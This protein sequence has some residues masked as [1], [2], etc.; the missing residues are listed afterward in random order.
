MASR[1]TTIRFDKGTL[2]LEE[3]P[4]F[5]TQSALE[6]KWDERTRTW[7]APAHRYR[8]IVLLLR[9]QG[10]P[11]ADRARAFSPTDFPLRSGLRPRD[12]QEAAMRAWLSG[13]RR[14][15]IVLPTG[16]GKTIVALLLIEKTRR[17]ALIHVPTIDLMHQW[18]AVLSEHFGG[19][20]GLLGGGYKELASLTVATYDSALLHVTSKG[21]RFGFLIFDECHHLPGPQYQFAALGSIAP[22]R[23]GLTA[24]PERADGRDRL[25]DDLVGPVCY[26]ARIRDLEGSTLAPYRVITREV[27]LSEAEAQA[28]A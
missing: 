23:L 11:Y 4:T 19:E 5:L 20:I 1:E 7:R 26:R 8:E 22:F 16:A 13:G 2:I 12:Y 25:L 9:A 24:T 17:P 6:V 18:Y 10:V 3:V 15:V 21:N 14:G 28:Y 27:E